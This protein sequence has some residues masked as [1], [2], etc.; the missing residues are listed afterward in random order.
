[1]EG[2]TNQSLSSGLLLASSHT[3]K[4][5]TVCA[6]MSP[7]KKPVDRNRISSKRRVSMLMGL[8]KGWGKS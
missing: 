3:G 2:Y 8:K 1:V 6:D 5:L 4:P 7:E